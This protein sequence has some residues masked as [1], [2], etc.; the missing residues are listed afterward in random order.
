MTLVQT[1]EEI[2][3]GYG[4]R[5]RVLCHNEALM[6]VAFSF[7]EGGKG[8][9]HNHPH[10]QSTYVESGRFTFTVDAISF[11]VAAG[12]CF[13]IPANAVHGCACR[14][15]GRLVDT[16]APRRDDFLPEQT[17]GA[18]TAKAPRLR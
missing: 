4:V 5:R 18:N 7:E 8:L 17:D 13:V 1:F 9:P 2:D 16:F 10:T 12:D 14:E 11:D 15:A 3:A 6:V